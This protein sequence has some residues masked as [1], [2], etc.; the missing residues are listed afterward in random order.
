[1]GLSSRAIKW[2]DS[3]LGFQA[4]IQEGLNLK[5]QATRANMAALIAFNMANMADTITQYP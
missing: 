2:Q 5:A 4:K 1:V 3:C